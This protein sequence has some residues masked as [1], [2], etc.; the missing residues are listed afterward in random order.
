MKSEWNIKASRL[1][2]AELKRAGITYSEL[3]QRLTAAGLPENKATVG[4]KMS[5]GTFSAVFL[6]A[7]LKVIGLEWLDL[8]LL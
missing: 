3:A 1:L 4:N 2:K 7:S 6:L 5:E 8:Q